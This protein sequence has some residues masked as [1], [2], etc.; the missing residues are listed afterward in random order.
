MSAKSRGHKH[1]PKC[2]HNR[3]RVH[4]PPV[5][6][7]IEYDGE[8]IVIDAMR[9]WAEFAVSDPAAPDYGQTLM[10]GRL[11]LGHAEQVVGN[12]GVT[13]EEYIEAIREM[14]RAGQLGIGPDGRAYLGEPVFDDAGQLVRVRRYTGVE[15]DAWA[16]RHERKWNESHG[17]GSAPG[18]EA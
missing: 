10:L 15:L 9:A 5:Q 4:T 3:A 12:Y 16:D 7:G 17:G 18:G 2:P 1:S 14:Y 11:V 8:P 13:V 6:W